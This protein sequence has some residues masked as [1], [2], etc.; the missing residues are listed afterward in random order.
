VHLIEETRDRWCPGTALADLGEYVEPLLIEAWGNHPAERRSILA[1]I[2]AVIR[3]GQRSSALRLSLPDYWDRVAT[4]QLN[5]SQYVDD[6]DIV[7]GRRRGQVMV[8]LR[9]QEVILV[10]VKTL[11]PMTDFAVVEDLEVDA[12]GWAIPLQRPPYPGP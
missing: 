4:F 6:P 3:L 5:E 12:D 1:G 7:R 11:Q 9:V 2:E 8:E 10:D